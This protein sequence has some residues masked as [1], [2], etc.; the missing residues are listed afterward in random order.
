MAKYN[1]EKGLKEVGFIPNTH[2]HEKS[3][4]YLIRSANHTIK[5]LPYPPKEIM[6]YGETKERHTASGRRDYRSIFQAIE[7]NNISWQEIDKVYEFGCANSRVLRHFQNF[8]SKKEGR[9]AWGSDINSNTLSWSLAN[10]SPPFNFFVN[11]TQPHIPMPDEYFDLIY[12]YSIFTHI[13]DLFFTW[14]FELR[15]ILGKSKYL[16]ISIHD[17][18]SV[19]F[20]L[21]HPER[22]IGKVAQKYKP[23]MNDLLKGKI[24]FLC[25]NRENVVQVFVRRQFIINKLSQWFNVVSIEEHTMAGHQTALLLQKKA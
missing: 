22:R 24:N 17:E 6:Q 15:R 20:G 25:L 14:I 10:L 1:K 23:L 13:D 21:E 16:Y 18:N 9:E 11:T 8:I 3:D 12:A 5:N 2:S 7:T 4:V 19:R